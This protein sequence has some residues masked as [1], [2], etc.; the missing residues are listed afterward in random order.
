M[1]SSYQ[2]LVHLRILKVETELTFDD[3]V[4]SH[5]LNQKTGH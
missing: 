2:F 3:T 1:E 5:D 4:A